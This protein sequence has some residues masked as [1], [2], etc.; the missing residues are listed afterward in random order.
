MELL[1]FRTEAI[2][3]LRMGEVEIGK[4]GDDEEKNTRRHDNGTLEKHK[5]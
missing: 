2:F 1:P 5:G 3:H 4:E